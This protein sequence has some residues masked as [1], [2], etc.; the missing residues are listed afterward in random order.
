MK[1]IRRRLSA[2]ISII[3]IVLVLVCAIAVGLSS[4]FLYRADNIRSNA[5]RAQNV[6]QSVAALVDAQ[7][8]SEI[9]ESGEK[10]DYWY[11]VKAILNNIKQRTQVKYLYV[12]DSDYTDAMVYFA[13]GY[14]P[15]NDTEDELDLGYEEVIEY[16]GVPT[17]ADELFDTIRTGQPT[18]SQL[19]ESG[20]FGTMVSG[21]AAIKNANGQVVGVVGVDISLNEVMAATSAF[22]LRIILII[23]GFCIVSGFFTVWLINRKVGAPVKALTAAANQMATGDMDLQLEV[24]RED[25]IGVLSSAFEAMA[26]DTRQ[27]AE[28]LARLAQGDLTMQI[29]PRGNKDLMSQAMARMVDNLNALFEDVRQSSTHT[30][31]GAN[32]I[33]SGAQALASAST[34]QAATLQQFSA[35]IGEVLHQSEENTNEATTTY[36]DTLQAGNLM[37]SSMDAMDK[38]AG[39]MHNINSSSE[40]IAGIIKVVDDIAFQTNLLAL[41]A[42]VEAARAGQHGRGFAVVADEVRNLAAKS[43]QA[44]KETSVMIESNMQQVE[45]GVTITTETQQTMQSVN[46]ISISNAQAIER[47]KNASSLQ[48]QAIA[49]INQGISNLSDVVQANSA[50]AEESA[51]S[52]QEMSYQAQVLDSIVARFQLKEGGAPGVPRLKQ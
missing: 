11:T 48:S 3:V 40:K 28:V 19:Y 44:A 10:T 18:I 45:E 49:E 34:Q 30:A 52:A 14:D 16:D 36:E 13:E 25:E 29:V 5:N 6:A 42:A 39:S 9:M 4:F 31:N 47:I 8:F 35:S 17:Y 20:D 12:L 50:T 51:A 38:L 37:R 24:R 15:A 21:F 33:A 43:A 1:Q 23:L 7:A 22:A 26:N 2:Q 27:Q 32:Q 46:E 41:N